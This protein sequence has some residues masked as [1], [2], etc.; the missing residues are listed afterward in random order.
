MA[1]GIKIIDNLTETNITLCQAI[2]RDSVGILIAIIGLLYVFGIFIINPKIS[3]SDK[4]NNDFLVWICMI[5]ILIEL[6]TMYTNAKRR[7]VHDFIAN[8]VVVFK[9]RH[10]TR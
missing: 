5:W 7:A 6:V 1:I 8:T 4:I 9:K 2:Y 3:I 10:T